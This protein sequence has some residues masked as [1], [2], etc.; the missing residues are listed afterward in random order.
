ML[1]F[2]PG[3]GWPSLLVAPYVAEV[4]GVDGSA[5]RVA[6]CAANADRMGIRNAS[7]IHNPPHA[8]LPFPDNYFDG[9][10]AA[11]SIEQTP[12]PQATLREIY[13]VLKPGG[14]LR[15]LYEGLGRYISHEQ[16]V[17]LGDLGASK[18][19]IVELCGG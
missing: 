5:K 15:M 9:V 11:S 19:R 17:W 12:D 4:M 3:D 8:P 2:G 13:R 10:L 16:E 1:D 7:F 18:K 14:H 6:V